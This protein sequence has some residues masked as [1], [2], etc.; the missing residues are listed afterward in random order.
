MDV[1]GAQEA[2]D[3]LDALEPILEEALDC[4][5]RPDDLLT[6]TISLVAFLKHM[7]EQEEEQG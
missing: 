7:E 2:L 5:S 3:A 1:C 4:A 6:R